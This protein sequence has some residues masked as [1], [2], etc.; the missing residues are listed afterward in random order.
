[1]T[2]Y[3]AIALSLLAAVTLVQG[4]PPQSDPSLKR[5]TIVI[6]RS[7]ASSDTG[8]AP[9]DERLGF[10][11]ESQGLV[12]TSFAALVREDTKALRATTTVQIV[13]QDR[14]HP[15]SIVGIEPTLNFAILKIDGQRPFPAAKW[16]GIEDVS[17]GQKVYALTGFQD[18]GQPVFT[19]GTITDLNSKECYQHSM[20]A[21]MLRARIEIPASAIGGPVYNERGEVVA[22]Y[23]GHQPDPPSTSSIEGE[24]TNSSFDQERHRAIEEANR[25]KCHLLPIFLVANIYES[26]KLKKSLK[27]P[28]T[29]FSV[30]ALTDEEAA[31]FPYDYGRKRYP[32]A[33][34]VEHV[35]ED[36]P[37]GELG[38]LQDDLL[39]GFSYYHCK[40]VAQF[41][42]WL[43]AYGVGSEI[44][45][46]FL[47][48]GSE[49]RTVTYTIEERPKWA[50]PQ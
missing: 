17:V 25:G 23:T 48:N 8:E 43:Y 36:G 33:V 11:A 21:T 32:G 37:A 29:G 20:T 45:L 5:P 41:Q 39:L 34:A 35:W 12:L 24:L 16:S 22:I 9:A 18:G 38:I 26:L 30:R 3:S 47:R 31:L 27:S 40:S 6:V 2:L 28:W 10:I 14:R 15:A 44:K 42:K 19:S 7:Y 13:E 46:Y 1:M 4:V 49:E 50:V